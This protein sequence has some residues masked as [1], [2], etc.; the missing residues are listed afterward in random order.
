MHPVP[1]IPGTFME[2]KMVLSN[3]YTCSD[4]QCSNQMVLSLNF[5]ASLGTARYKPYLDGF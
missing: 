3:L 5:I 2:E 1:A 4:T